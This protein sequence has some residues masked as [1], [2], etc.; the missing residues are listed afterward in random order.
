MSSGLEEHIEIIFLY[1]HQA[2]PT[3]KYQMNLTRII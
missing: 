3:G 2:G 1:G